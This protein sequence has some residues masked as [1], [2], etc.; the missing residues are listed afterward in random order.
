HGPAPQAAKADMRV[1][2]KNRPF[3]AYSDAGVAGISGRTSS[4]VAGLS[5]PS[6]MDL[7]L[8]PSGT[9]YSHALCPVV[10]EYYRAA[11]PQSQLIPCLGRPITRRLIDDLP[12]S[13]T[14]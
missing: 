9:G 8:G 7:A 2:K 13:N 5:I 4:P 1:G 3:R 6:G 10:Y 11:R 12:K 14:C